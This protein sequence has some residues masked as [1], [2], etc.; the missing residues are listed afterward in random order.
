MMR[1]NTSV[2]LALAVLLVAFVGTGTF[3]HLT[4][5]GRVQLDFLLKLSRHRSFYLFQGMVV[6]E[7]SYWP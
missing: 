7:R 4:S 3:E 6:Q 5:R 2:P 1:G